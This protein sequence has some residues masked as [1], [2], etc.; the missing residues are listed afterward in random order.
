MIR[1][2]QR[3]KTIYSVVENADSQGGKGVVDGL[4]NSLRTGDAFAR[5]FVSL[6]S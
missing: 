1:R 5:P 6:A 2:T 3:R 4:L